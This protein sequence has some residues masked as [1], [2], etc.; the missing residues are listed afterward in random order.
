MAIAMKVMQ[1]FHKMAITIQRRQRELYGSGPDAVAG[2]RLF[3]VYREGNNIS[4]SVQHNF[5]KCCTDWT[6]CAVYIRNVNA[7]FQFKSLR[8][9][10][11]SKVE[12]FLSVVGCLRV[13][14]RVCMCVYWYVHV[15]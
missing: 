10:T 6:D 15:L 2:F 9:Q 8:K 1:N 12:I 3:F 11:P 14:V 13:C 7:S 5:Y 4:Q